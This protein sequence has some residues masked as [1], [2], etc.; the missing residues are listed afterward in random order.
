MTETRVI[1]N[2]MMQPSLGE[3]KA[4]IAITSCDMDARLRLILESAIT[5]AERHIGKIIP[6]SRF[7][8]VCEFA[9]AIRLPHV[10]VLEVE[11]VYVD[12]VLSS[13]F[14]VSKGQILFG[15]SV[16]GDTCKIVYKAGML[17]V[18]ADLKMAIFLIAA[19]QFNNPMD[20]VETLPTASSN[21]LRGYRT[22]HHYDK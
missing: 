21:I 18:P 2:D 9:K 19:R 7:T 15:E 11:A 17:Q 20:T 6:Q 14:V 5:T 12:N 1:L 13:D 3:F 10:P 16:C 4:H 22:W 8:C